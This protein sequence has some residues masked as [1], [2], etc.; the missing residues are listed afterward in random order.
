VV[1]I[2]GKEADDMSSAWEAG[3][4]SVVLRKDPLSTVVLAVMSAGLR[5]LKTAIETRQT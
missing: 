5:V 1:L 3:V 2:A 4:T